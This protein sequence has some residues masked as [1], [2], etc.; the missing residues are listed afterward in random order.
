MRLFLRRRELPDARKLASV[1]TEGTKTDHRA[2]WAPAAGLGAIAVL[3]A[4]VGLALAA[5][6]HPRHARVLPPLPKPAASFTPIPTPRAAGPITG[7]APSVVD[8]PA[9]HR[10]VLFGGVD[11]TNKTWQ[12]DGRHWTS[13][14]PPTSPPNRAGAAAAYDPATRVV[15]L[16]GGSGST[17]GQA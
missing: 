12:W 2:R 11:S 8:D 14:T 5:A 6:Q 17:P 3:V 7:L 9:T 16:F 4:G 10:V 1:G 15:M 13:T